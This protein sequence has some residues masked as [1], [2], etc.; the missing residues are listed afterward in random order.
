MLED[1]LMRKTL[2]SPETIEDLSPS[3]A[4]AFA[5]FHKRGFGIAVGVTVALVVALVTG[6]TIYFPEEQQFYLSLLSQYFYGYTVSWTGV[7]VGAFWGFVAGFVAGW[8]F[9]FCRNLVI[10]TI[11]FV[12]RT[13]AELAATKDF[14]DHI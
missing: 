2:D 8:F 11:V 9:A 5:P 1:V 7:V 12:T 3:V 6:V 4:L 14:L 10:A 13:R